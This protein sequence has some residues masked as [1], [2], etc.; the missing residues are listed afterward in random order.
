MEIIAHRGLWKT[1]EERNQWEALERAALTNMGTETDFRDFNRKLVISHDMPTEKAV[2]V[3]K[4]LELYQAAPYTLAINI[5]ADGLQTIL[6]QLLDKYQINNYFCFDMAIPDTLGY[7]EKEL[8]FFTRESE[9]EPFPAF[10]QKA[11]GVWLDG[12][13]SD[14]WITEEKI[15]RHLNAGKAVCIV[16][17]ELHQR[18]HT[19]KWAEYKQFSCIDSNRLIFCTDYPE[20]AKE[21]FYHEKN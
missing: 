21:Y 16:S 6:K 15:S 3:E 2:A 5:K 11:A 13:E 14:D 1:F 7:I 20:E 17:P 18:H 9:Y 8:K 19:K 10:Y 4:F 12:F